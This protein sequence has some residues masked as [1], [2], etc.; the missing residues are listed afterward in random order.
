M[1]TVTLTFLTLL[2]ETTTLWASPQ[3]TFAPAP[4]SVQAYDFAELTVNVAAP[5]REIPSRT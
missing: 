3:V 2:L 5:M 4:A 1:R